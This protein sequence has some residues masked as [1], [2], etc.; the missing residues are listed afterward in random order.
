MRAVH[1]V[2]IKETVHTMQKKKDSYD[3]ICHVCGRSF[4]PGRMA[5]MRLEHNGINTYWAG[6]CKMCN[7]D[8]LSI[9][10]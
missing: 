8:D 4:S 6:V 10:E 7:G 5:L 9:E 2:K 1:N 3:A